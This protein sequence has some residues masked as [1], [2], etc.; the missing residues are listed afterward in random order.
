MRAVYSGGDNVYRALFAVDPRAWVNKQV[1][2]TGHWEMKWGEGDQVKPIGDFMSFGSYG[3]LSSKSVVERF[4]KFAPGNIVN[5][6]LV[7]SEEY[8]LLKPRNHP[9]DGS[10]LEHIFIMFRGGDYG[11]K[12]LLVTQLV[13]DE[14][15]GLG[16]TGAVF[17]QVAEMDD[18]R[19]I[20][21]Q[22]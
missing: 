20:P 7:G 8:A 17:E 2:Y 16:L 18:T 21:V 1:G 9:V 12:S 13:K 11:Y 4:L 19:F 10:N 5:R 22:A 3:I 6:I 15:E 14:W